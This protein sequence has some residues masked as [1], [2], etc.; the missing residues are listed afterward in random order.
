[1][2]GTGSGSV[3]EH[4]S[5]ADL[6]CR[7]EQRAHAVVVSPV[8]AI[9]LA[10]QATFADAVHDALHRKTSTVVIDLAGVTFLGSPGLA[11]LV[12]AQ[13]DAMRLGRDLHVAI[14]NELVRRSIELTGLAAI[15]SLVPDVQAALDR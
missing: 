2:S 3:S 14:G 5:Y 7:I 12:E 13:E 10:A 11:V 9:D 8:G 15:L 6:N 4:D 1:M